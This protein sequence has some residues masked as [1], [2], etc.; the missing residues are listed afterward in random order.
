VAHKAF[1]DWEP[2]RQEVIELM[3]QDKRDEASEITKGR[4]AGH[5]AYMDES[6]ETMSDFVS[7]K[8]ASFFDNARDSRQ[9]GFIRIFV[10]FLAI[11]GTCILVGILIT[12]S[13]TKPISHIMEGISKVADGN[14][15]H[16]INMERGDEIGELSAAFDKM[17]V[18]L[19]KT[20][21][22]RDELNTANQ[23]LRA[24]EARYRTLYESSQDAIMMLA[25]PSWKFIGGNPATVG[26]FGAKDEEG[27]VSKGP[28]ELSPEYQP[29]GQL[30]SEMAKKMI[31]K[32]MK[33]G[34]ADSD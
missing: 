16:K 19:R 7:K 20:T 5:V 30:S 4:G 22:S 29:D 26:L 12:R 25:P 21:A 6:I 17:T 14:L 2:I 24:S 31:E 10:L 27:F 34:F 8:A 18:D 9:R 1:S 3:H 33:E 11:S 15:D 28:W 23:Q 13:I 32:A